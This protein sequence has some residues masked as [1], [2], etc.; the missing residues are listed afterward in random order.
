MIPKGLQLINFRSHKNTVI[1]LSNITVAAILGDNGI[2]KSSIVLAILY[3]LWGKIPKYTLLELVNDG[4]AKDM[5]VIYDFE[6]EDGCDYRIERSVKVSGKTKKTAI[7]TLT[8]SKKSDSGKWVDISGNSIN[9]TTATIQKMLGGLTVD[10][11]MYS[12]LAMQDEFSRFMDAEPSERR[13]IFE[14][15]SNVG[16]YDRL[17]KKAKRRAD[18]AQ[19]VIKAVNLDDDLVVSGWSTRL[20]EI[21]VE[22]RQLEQDRQEKEKD[23]S[24]FMS[25]KAQLTSSEAFDVKGDKERLAS[26][27]QQLETWQAKEIET[28]ENLQEYSTLISSKDKI[29]ADYNRFTALRMENDKYSELEREYS[30]IERDLAAEKSN[31]VHINQLQEK[32]I[33][34]KVRL[35]QKSDKIK[36]DLRK[37]YAIESDAPIQASLKEKIAD[38]TEGLTELAQKKDSLV[39]E[40]DTLEQKLTSCRV[41]I[42]DSQASLN[43]IAETIT[44]LKGSDGECPFLRKK[45]SKISGDSLASEILSLEKR[46]N[47]LKAQQVV[48]E[49]TRT[50]I[51]ELIDSTKKE[52]YKVE[53]EAKGIEK[54]IVG[55]NADLKNAAAQL[56]EIKQLTKRLD[57]DF[58][59]NFKAMQEIEISVGNI[60]K[61]QQACSYDRQKHDTCRTSLKELQATEISTLYQALL[62]AGKLYVTTKEQL[63]DIQDNLKRAGQ[64]STRLTQVI[65]DKQKRLDAAEP[66]LKRIE[67]AIEKAN[68]ELAVFA[69]NKTALV[70][71]QTNCKARIEQHERTKETISAQQKTYD[72]HINLTKAYQMAK[73]F[74]VENSIPRYQENCNRMLEYLGL[75]IRVRIETLEEAKDSKPDK[76]KFNKVFKII[77]INSQGIERSYHTWSGGEK[78]RVNLALRHALSMTLLNRSGV[79]MGLVVIDEGDTRL[80]SAGKE[81]LLKVIDATSNGEFGFPAKVLFITHAEDLKDRLPTRIILS[82][83]KNGTKVT[84][85]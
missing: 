58:D 63:A 41:A 82:A 17:G 28:K 53:Q 36:A 2:G 76:P 33:A 6:H 10:A 47:L 3:V 27:M 67:D 31:L 12:N 70:V 18:D 46:G 42:S 49:T 13:E 78:H 75:N 20:K 55:I 5:S 24:A 61:L 29:T 83:G 71:E 52:A 44:R 19:A 60:E 15:I 11:A 1:D 39:A 25:A 84:I 77:V 59:G 68:N 4:G 50:E 72:T 64:E 7:S 14:T 79:K 30:Q 74:I 38:L 62:T 34:E 80:D 9:A 8:L 16:I 48:I 23:L 32:I 51:T 54:T 37:Q 85:N 69:E 45:C 73:A 22:L 66:E 57:D 40:Q 35:Q 56:S 65:A 81:A 43:Q 26:L 21:D